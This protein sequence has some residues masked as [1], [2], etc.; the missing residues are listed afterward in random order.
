[1]MLWIYQKFT[2]ASSAA[3]KESAATQPGAWD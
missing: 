3:P 2:P 1:L